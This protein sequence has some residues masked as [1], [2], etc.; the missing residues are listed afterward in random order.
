MRS[1]SSCALSARFADARASATMTRWRVSRRPCDVI[2]DGI[3]AVVMDRGY[4][5][6]LTSS[7]IL[8]MLRLGLISWRWTMRGA[9]GLS[10]AV[11]VV[12]ACRARPTA[13]GGTTI[14]LVGTENFYADLLTQIG[15]TRRAAPSCLT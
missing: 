7:L 6:S 2:R 3:S 14:P 10:V 9:V 12:A 13:S 1:H 11:L 4:A 15:G 8:L 5:A